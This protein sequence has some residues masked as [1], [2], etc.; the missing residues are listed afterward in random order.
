MIS[1]APSSILP[2]TS[3]NVTD[4]PVAVVLA[5]YGSVP[6][7][8]RFAAQE[9]GFPRGTML[10]AETDRGQE[11]VMVL[12]CLPPAKDQETTGSILR[13]AE[14]AELELAAALADKANR[15]YPEW[16]RRVHDWKL[17]LELIDLEQ[18][19]DGRL[20]L[21][22]LNDRGAE[23]TRLALLTA[24]NGLGIVHVQ[25]VTADGVV[26]PSG[27]GCGSGGCGSGGGGCSPH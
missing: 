6:Q 22:V 23:T 2:E 10:V 18:T 20:I 16:V 27:G 9:T 13:R 5:R 12:Q 26:P 21:Y 17:Q 4:P 3:G 19:L 14:S 25:P 8:A 15:Q 11:L 24:A 7:V 1:E